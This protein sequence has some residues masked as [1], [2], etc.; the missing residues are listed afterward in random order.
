MI[1]SLFN[2]T[3]KFKAS[4]AAYSLLA[5]RVE[6]LMHGIRDLKEK[7]DWIRSTK[8]DNP[9]DLHYLYERLHVEEA[10]QL[11][12]KEERRLKKW[13]KVRQATTT[14]SEAALAT[15]GSKEQSARIRVI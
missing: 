14:I 4:P 6:N 10:R 7:Y 15:M 3:G 12:I 11:S 8:L 1:L 2:D 13:P 5:D 9:P